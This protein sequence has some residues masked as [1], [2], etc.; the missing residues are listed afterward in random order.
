MLNCLL[1][2]HM[3]SN[4]SFI[5]SGVLICFS[6]F[7][8]SSFAW[9]LTLALL[10][11]VEVRFLRRGLGSDGF[12]IFPGRPLLV[13]ACGVQKYCSLISELPSLFS[14]S[15]LSDFACL[16]S[17]LSLFCSSSGTSPRRFSWFQGPVLGGC[18]DLRQRPRTSPQ[19][20]GTGLVWSDQHPRSFSRRSQRGPC[21]FPWMSVGYFS[22]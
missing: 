22:G 15:T 17:L 6:I 2:F 10:I 12:S 5:F 7:C 11:F 20:S 4:F 16:S 13:S 19:G 3:F 14:L 9:V 18:P 1:F 21:T 8:H